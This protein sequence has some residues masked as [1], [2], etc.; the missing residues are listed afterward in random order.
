MHATVIFECMRILS[1]MAASAGRTDKIWFPLVL[2]LTLGEKN[3]K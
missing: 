1:N 3:Q 2:I